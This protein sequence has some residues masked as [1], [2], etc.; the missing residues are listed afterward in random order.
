MIRVISFSTS[1]VA[2]FV[3]RGKVKSKLN[4]DHKEDDI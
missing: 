1:A 4:F 3:M 2:F